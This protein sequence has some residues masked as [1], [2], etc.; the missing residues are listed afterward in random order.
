M[1]FIIMHKTNALW[2]SGALPAPDV[3][4]RVGAL[5]GDLNAAGVLRA[6]DGLRASSEGVR[7]TF[8]GGVRTVVPGPFT[9]ANELPAA[10]DV[11]RA[12]SVENAIE[13]AARE[14]A[15]LGDLEVDIRPVTEAWDIGLAPPPPSLETRRY[16]VL[17][18][19]N[20]A[21]E[22]GTL[23]TAAQRVDLSKL[24]AD[25][26]NLHLTT[27]AMRPSARGRR[28]LNIANGVAV[29]DGPFVESKELLAGFVIVDV[30]SLDEAVAWARR[31]IGVVETTEVDVR[32]LE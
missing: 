18:K 14:A 32:E 17:R 9:G 28:L 29:Y 3:I 25:T 24:I 1:L 12:S 15:I 20:A 27:A 10:F 4:A 31:Y 22:A 16:M 23:P 8:S 7:V 6:G 30:A 21:S 2:E 26:A 5:I 11:I 19:A 13:W